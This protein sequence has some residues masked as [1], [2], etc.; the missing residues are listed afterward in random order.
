V[1]PRP[2]GRSGA[3]LVYG[4]GQARRAYSRRSL[5][6]WLPATGCIRAIHSPEAPGDR[7]CT[8]CRSSGQGL[9]PSRCRSA[10][11]ASEPGTGSGQLCL[12]GQRKD[13]AIEQQQ[14]R[15]AAHRCKTLGGLSRSTLV[16]AGL[17]LSTAR[18]GSRALGLSLAASTGGFVAAS[19]AL[20]VARHWIE[21]GQSSRSA[22][23]R[24]RCHRRRGQL[25]HAAR[26]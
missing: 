20:L 17:G 1:R 6:H 22:E 23:G 18:P 3:D 19:R 7:R 14:P 8:A 10:I 21:Q 2:T 13:C 9:E 16:S 4:A 25:S 12:P 26:G 11:S 5:P 24:G 15:L